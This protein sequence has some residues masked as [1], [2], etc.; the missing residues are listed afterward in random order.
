MSSPGRA[1]RLTPPGKPLL[2]RATVHGHRVAHMSEQPT[3]ESDT[4][5]DARNTADLEKADIAAG[6]KLARHRDHPA[7]RAAGKASKIGDQGPL[8]AMSAGVLIVGMAARDRRL[9]E[10]GVSMLAAVAVADVSKRLAK[11]LVRRTDVS[12][13][14]AKALVRR[15]R[16]HVL[17]NEHRYETDAGGSD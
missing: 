2:D 12:K 14:L 13:R 3:R 15:T 16:P 10:S 5:P 17:L 4:G 7:A 1:P 6:A 9:G 11:A 8:Y